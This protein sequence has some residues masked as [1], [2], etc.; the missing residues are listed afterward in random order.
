MLS[1][2]IVALILTIAVVTILGVA[3]FLTFFSGTTR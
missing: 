2:E 3:A 1:P